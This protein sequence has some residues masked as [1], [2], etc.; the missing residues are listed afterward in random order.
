MKCWNHNAT[1]GDS[2]REAVTNCRS[3]LKPYCGDCVKLIGLFH[4]P[5]CELCRQ[6]TRITLQR[7]R[8]R[9]VVA[10]VGSLGM[11]YY[12]WTC[13]SYLGSVFG[14]ESS[15]AF[16]SQIWTAGAGAAAFFCIVKLL[17]GQAQ[18]KAF[19]KPNT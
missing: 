17:S 4:Y 3:C 13:A 11:A 15:A 1:S 7:D 19:L 9:Y 14:Y 18:M 16:A 2:T 12:S 10:L 6:A 5:Y 8:T